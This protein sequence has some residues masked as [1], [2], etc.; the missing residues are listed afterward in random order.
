MAIALC[1]SGIKSL[2]DGQL[3]FAQSSRPVEAQELAFYQEPFV[4][5]SLC[6]NKR[7]KLNIEAF[8]SGSYPITGNL[9]VVVKQ[10]GQ[11]KQQAGVAYA[12][13][14]LTEQGQELITQAGFVK[15]RSPPAGS[16]RSWCA[17]A[18][19]INRLC[20][21]ANEIIPLGED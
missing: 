14:L 9:F 7:N 16:R 2:I 11:I 20:W 8:Q 12:N 5:A 4:T 3:T 17:L 21:Q 10:N 13:L 15:I 19:S 6:P 1:G 18:D